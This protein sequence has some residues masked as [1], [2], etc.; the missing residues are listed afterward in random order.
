MVPG[1][2]WLRGMN[3]SSVHGTRSSSEDMQT[4]D[5]HRGLW[6]IVDMEPDGSISVLEGRSSDPDHIVTASVYPDAS[7]RVRYDRVSKNR[8]TLTFDFVINGKNEHWVDACSRS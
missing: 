6:R 8:Y 4:Y 3:R 1:S 2:T 5:A 7:Q